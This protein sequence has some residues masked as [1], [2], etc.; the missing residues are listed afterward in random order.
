VADAEFL[1]G[2]LD[3]ARLAARL[4]HPHI[5]QTNE[6]GHDAANNYFIAMEYLDGQPLQRLRHRAHDAGRRL[7]LGLTLKVL[8]DVLEGLHYAHEVKDYD[9]TA[10]NVV[11]R[12]ISPQNIFVT[13]AGEVKILDFGIAKAIGS[14]DETRAGVYKGKLR[15]MSPEQMHGDAVDRRADVFS[16]GVILWAA[17]AGHTLWH[18]LANMEVARRLYA[19]QIPRLV[20][21]RPDAPAALVRICD[22]ALAPR[23]EDRYASA[24]ELRADLQ[25]FVDAQGELTTRE[26]LAAAMQELFGADQQQMQRDIEEYVRAARSQ[27]GGAAGAALPLVA[28]SSE[29]GS[30]RSG[31]G[32]GFRASGTETAGQLAGPA[33]SGNGWK[34]AAIA[35]PLALLSGA[36]AMYTV[37]GQRREQPPV[38]EPAP[39]RAAAVAPAPAVAPPRPTSAQLVVRATPT[40]AT[41]SVDGVVV[42]NPHKAQ[43]PLGTV[44]E[45][46]VEAAGFKPESRSVTVD[47]AQLV[48]F[49]LQRDEPPAE[50][51]RPPP[52]NPAPASPARKRPAAPAARR[53]APPAPAIRTVP[54]PAQARPAVE[55]LPDPAVQIVE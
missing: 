7:E 22:K 9:G 28:A 55:I 30:E 18:G 12:D 36:G 48:D 27:T 25:A 33:P 8:L 31:T 51:A 52:A 49:W 37:L 47:R 2:F 20:D 6:V 21:A 3:E 44:H 34:V 11:H 17:V 46:R 32:S 39:G 38:A 40:E 26:Q 10:L 41:V 1:Q 5:V 42:E 4:S 53:A 43:V 23:V 13:Y 19:G 16:V 50:A 14:T 29:L 15:Y 35:I 45:I 54:E 24:A